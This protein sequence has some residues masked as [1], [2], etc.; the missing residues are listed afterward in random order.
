[1][2]RFCKTNS[3]ALKLQCQ[4]NGLGKQSFWKEIFTNGATTAG[5]LWEKSWKKSISIERGFHFPHRLTSSA[6]DWPAW[7]WPILRLT[8]S[9][10]T[11]WPTIFLLGVEKMKAE[12]R[13][14]KEDPLKTSLSCNFWNLGPS[15]RPLWRG[16]ASVGPFRRVFQELQCHS[17]AFFGVGGVAGVGDLRRGAPARRPG[18]HG[19]RQHE[20]PGGLPG[21]YDI[22]WS[23][24]I[25]MDCYRWT[26]QVA[27]CQP[28]AI[29][30]D[31]SHLNLHKT[32]CI[33][34]GGGGPGMGPIGV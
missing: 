3:R 33:P 12:S 30:A 19:R 16:E 10:R 34:H 31:V 13:P 17:N 18:V 14:S 27:L 24:T 25:R 28:A 26:L 1:M 20:R 4:G 8:A 9:S 29:G 23:L 22:W 5:E 11:R 7:C 21:F 6:T 32:F 2:R 15:R